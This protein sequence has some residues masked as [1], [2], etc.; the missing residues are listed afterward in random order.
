MNNKIYRTTLYNSSLLEDMRNQNSNHCKDEC[1]RDT[2][3]SA[4]LKDN[5][6][7]VLKL[8]CCTFGITVLA[9][10]IAGDI[11][12][13]NVFT[14]VPEGLR[15]LLFRLDDDDVLHSESSADRAVLMVSSGCFRE[16]FDMSSVS[17]LSTAISIDISSDVIG[18]SIMLSQG[19]VWSCPT[20]SLSPSTV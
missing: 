17:A 5:P 10:P 16:S 15:K 20:W 8:M 9:T 11:S 1:R 6:Q 18:S 12:G 2:H 13:L 4:T 14:I 3:G 7:K 19:D